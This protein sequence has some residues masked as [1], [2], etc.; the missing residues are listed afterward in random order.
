[1]EKGISVEEF[2]KR[3]RNVQSLMQKE[4]FDAWLIYADCWRTQNVRYFMDFAGLDGI[5]GEESCLLL[6]PSVGNPTLFA[7]HLMIPYAKNQSWFGDPV[8]ATDMKKFLKDFQRGSKCQRLGIAGFTIFPAPLYEQV[9]DVF[10]GSKIEV[11]DELLGKLKAVKNETEICLLRR[12]AQIADKG[13][14]GLERALKDGT[15]KTERELANIFDQTVASNGGQWAYY[16]I[17][18]SG[19]RSAWNH[20]HPSDRTVQEGD[21][22]YTDPGARYRGY[23]A[24]TARGITLGKVSSLQRKIVGATATAMEEAIRSIKPGVTK[25]SELNSLIEKILDEEGFSEFSK[26]GKEHGNGHG[27]GTDPADLVPWIG[28]GNQTVLEKNMVFCL[29]ASVFVPEVGGA[30]TEDVVLVAER[31]AEA[32]NKFPY[33]NYW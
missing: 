5:S 4:G 18:L 3:T 22:L 29:K 19:P 24:D 1:M 26:E 7:A 33:R 6:L 28:E 8:N 23:V 31:G 12:A 10:D 16:T 30:R 21:S 20:G 17:V 14:E 25:C 15:P 2:K 9:K 11:V 13:M 27:T 32:L